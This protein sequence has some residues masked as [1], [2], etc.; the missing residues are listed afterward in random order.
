MSKLIKRQLYKIDA[1]EEK[2]LNK[3]QSTLFKE[4][5]NPTLDNLESKIPKELKEKLDSAFVAGFKMVFEK[6]TQTIEKAYDKQ[7]IDLEYEL[8]NREMDRN[9]RPK[10]LKAIDRNAKRSRMLGKIVATAEGAGFGFLG[11]GLPDIPI[12]IGVILKG[13]YEI[14]ASYGFTYKESKEKIFILKVIRAAVAQGKEK[15]EADK[16]VELWRLEM[17]KDN[18]YADLEEEIRKTAAALSQSMLVAKFIQGLPIVGATGSIFNYTMYSK[19]TK[20]AG[21]KYKKRYLLQKL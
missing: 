2:V 3:K 18:I 5:I 8:Y 20:Y 10:Y 15:L 14:S 4:K 19:I 21:V 7:R 12:F 17:Q 9:P 6:G 1:I 16:E 11:I 13:I